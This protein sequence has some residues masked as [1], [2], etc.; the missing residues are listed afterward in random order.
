MKRPTEMFI[1]DNIYFENGVK[2]KDQH[3]VIVAG[4]DD[5]NLYC[6]A[7]TSQLKHVD[8]N[9][10]ARNTYNDNIYYVKTLPGKNCTV[11]N[12]K[13]GLIITSHCFPIPIAEANQYGNFGYLNPKTLEEV[14]VKWAYQQNEIKDKPNYNYNKICQVFGI[15]QNIKQ[16]DLYK[17]CQTLMSNFPNELQFQREYAKELRIYLEQ[18]Y[19]I[20]KEN[21]LRMA[22]GLPRLAFPT[23][24]K[25]KDDKSLFKQFAPES[26]EREPNNPFGDLF[27]ELY[28]DEP[29]K[30]EEK[31]PESN[32]VVEL[33]EYKDKLLRYQAAQRQHQMQ[34]MLEP[35]QQYE[36]QETHH[37][38]AA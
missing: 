20:S 31:Q 16:H 11:N 24:P 2:D 30:K 5:E 19:K 14:I 10:H 29:T 12:N 23:M 28:G 6:F 7:M 18:K 21:K 4:Y 8:K 25:L 13:Q 17:Y 9:S 35:E 27:K 26:I 38:R 34:N 15:N 22:Q 36:Q 3:P 1:Y 37:R 33:K 32:N